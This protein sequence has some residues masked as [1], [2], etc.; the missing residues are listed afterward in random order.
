MRQYADLEIGLRQAGGSHWAV[1]LRFS[2]PR[3]EADIVE[4]VLVTFDFDRLRGLIYDDAQYGLELG[5][6]L[7]GTPR[8]QNVFSQALAAAQA[9]GQPLRLRLYIGPGA[10]QLHTLRWETLRDPGDGASLVTGE[11]VLFSRYL[12][13]L[14][15]RPVGV[16]P[17]SHLRAL[18]IVAGPSHLSGYE[19]EGRKLAPIDVAAEVERAR[20]GLGDISV[21]TLAPGERATLERVT[22][23]LRDDY[24]ILY[25]VCHGYMANEEPQILLEEDNGHVARI[26]GSELMERFR[27]LQRLPRLV[28]LVSCQSAGSGQQDPHSRD[29]GALAALGPSLA[30]AGVPCVLAMQGNVSMSTV[31]HFMTRFFK[32]LHRDGQMDRAVAVARG[33]VRARPDWWAPVLFMRLK[34]GRIWYTPG[35]AS[36]Q[37]A[38]EKW[39][40]LLNDI[41]QRRCTPVLGPGLSD[42]VF[43][44]RQ[45]LARR[46]ASEY[47]YPLAPHYREDLPHVAQYL[48]VNLGYRF[49]RDELRKYVQRELLERYGPELSEEVRS[50]SF[51]QLM[52]AVGRY[53]RAVDSLEPHSVL[54]SLPFPVYVTTQP[55]EWLDAALLDA[56]KEPQ[57]ELCRW[58]R[59]IEVV[60]SVYDADPDYRPEPSRPLVYHLFG[61]I[62]HPDS[63]VLTEDDYFDFLIGVTGNKQL[64]PHAVRRSLADT[65][66]LFVGFRLDEWDFRVLYR[67]LMNQEGRGRRRKYVHVAAQVD[68]EEGRTL[69][70]ERARSYL[71]DYFQGAD[72]SI[73]WGSVDDFLRELDQ[74]WRA[75]A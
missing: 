73:Y 36:D 15:W 75:A 32:E 40:A 57:V 63:V 34:S 18:V 65:A 39:P 48:S 21:T 24:D 29:E 23:L 3:N 5:R 42:A 41:R 71:E 68:P 56:G 61:H 4:S 27:E 54:A 70:P 26:A 16:R 44:S 55:T 28:V 43:G 58:N 9:Q 69:E 1:E 6:S 49:P 31:A 72:I 46:W 17:K 7:L 19:A 20:A 64:I 25:L 12:S 60:S 59:D 51:Q 2:D 50:G 35:F 38:F 11:N 13:S 53:R 74:R 37:K 66:L 22:S 10:L 8:L 52:T 33:A 67:S 62:A 14:D 30:E 45:E 47:H